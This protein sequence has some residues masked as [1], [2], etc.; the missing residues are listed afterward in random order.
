MPDPK[1]TIRKGNSAYSK[2]QDLY[3]R[4][5]KYDPEDAPSKLGYEGF[6]V[7]QVKN[8]EKSKEKLVV[9]DKTEKEQLFLLESAPKERIAPNIK[10]IVKQEIVSGKV[11][12]VKRTVKRYAPSHDPECWN[13]ADHVENNNCYNYASTK[14]TDTFAQPGRAAN[15]MFPV[16]FYKAEDI[17]KAAIADGC[18]FKKAKKH[19]CAPSGDEHLVALVV[20]LGKSTLHFNKVDPKPFAI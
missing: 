13:G 10:D 9:G 4:V 20:Y 18:V 16:P 14:R 11:Q 7:Q 15:K 3:S 17:K 19:M 1:W 5:K 12:A 2:L 8:G 6:L